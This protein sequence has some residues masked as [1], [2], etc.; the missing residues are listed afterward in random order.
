VTHDNDPFEIN[1]RRDKNHDATGSALAGAGSVTAATGL[2]GG[3]IPGFKSDSDTIKNLRQ[4]SW[5]Q[6]TGAAMSSGRGGVFGYRV[7]AHQ[8]AKD[9]FE[10]DEK[11]FRDK[12]A[13]R[14]DSFMRGR[15]AGKIKPEADIIRHLK[16]GRRL[17]NAA[18]VGGVAAT[19]AGVKHAEN[20]KVSKSEDDVKRYH[21][22]LLGAGGTASVISI[23]G[24]KILRRQGKKWSDREAG[25]LRDA[26]KIVP[27]LKPHMSD[28]EARSNAKTFAGKSK[29][30]AEEAGRLRGAAAQERYFAHVYNHTA[31][32]AHRARYPA[33]AAAAVG[34]GGLLAASKKD[35]PVRSAKIKKDATMSN[36]FGVESHDISKADKTKEPPASGGRLVAGAL[37]PGVHAAA[38][39]K[40]NHKAR[41]AGY[42]LGGT[43]I[44]GPLGAG[45]GTHVAHERGHYKP[46][47]IKKNDPFEV[48]K[49]DAT[50]Q[51]KASRGRMAA[52]T[53]LPGYHGAIAGRQG[54]KLRAAGN[55]VGRGM[56]GTVLGG[57][58]GA[59]AGAAV[60]SRLGPEGKAA[61]ALTGYYAGGT[62]GGYMGT[63]SGTKA[64]QRKG[65]Y[66]PQVSKAFG[67]GAA[68]K[69]FATFAGG[70]TKTAGF[71]GGASSTMR[72]GGKVF[73]PKFTHTSGG[74]T[75]TTGGGLTTGAKVGLGTVVVGGA[76]TAGYRGARKKQ[77][78]Q[79][80]TGVTKAFGGRAAKKVGSLM[81]KPKVHSPLSITGGKPSSGL[82]LNNTHGV[83]GSLAPK[84]V[85]P[86]KPANV[87]VDALKAKVGLG[88]PKRGQAGVSSASV[89]RGA[90]Y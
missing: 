47:K 62:T 76:G 44:A 31:K 79:A 16:L 21:G 18:L 19:A 52:G 48:S 39:G 89:R 13:G 35:K 6:R 2:V 81:L 3:G 27:N 50:T 72:T 49:K 8:G 32:M 77:E 12:P 36:P 82:S 84:S 70:A 4:G 37:L 56:A 65:Y 17:S 60:G 30:K 14:T 20:K 83:A 58:A 85:Q 40:K 80:Q 55:E 11:Y 33:L 69:K 75:T 78:R 53:L 51:P 74:K 24:E 25:S 9:R 22:A 46:Q 63:H 59:L 42:E 7:D 87:D 1:K 45:V 26:A 41:A 61:G 28:N 43:V 54:K 10:N 73:K 34:A 68:A 86:F 15:T 88:K 38:A 66:K 67:G 90:G 71:H 57:T 5:K 64:A 23:G 29:A